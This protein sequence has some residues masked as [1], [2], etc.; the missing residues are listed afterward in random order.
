[1]SETRSIQA[2]LRARCAQE[3]AAW[4]ATR[5]HRR[6]LRAVIR[7]VISDALRLGR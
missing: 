5:Y 7:S 2:R 1:M 6:V 3:R 4:E